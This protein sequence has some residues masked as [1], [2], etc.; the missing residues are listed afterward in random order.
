[1]AVCNRQKH[2]RNLKLT[3]CIAGKM[4]N[5][6]LRLIVFTCQAAGGGKVR[7]TAVSLV[8]R[9]KLSRGGRERMQEVQR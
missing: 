9:V 7:L 8:S 2:S 4:A 1:M 3:K 5:N 6:R